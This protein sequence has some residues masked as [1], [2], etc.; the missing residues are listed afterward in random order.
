MIDINFGNL[1]TVELLHSYYKDQLCPDFNISASNQTVKTLGGHQIIARQ[2]YNQLIAGANCDTKVN[3]LKPFIAIEEGTQFTFFM[4]LNNPVFFNYTNL[5][6]T[7]PGKIYYFT[8]RNNNISNGKTFLTSKITAYNAANTY[9]PGDLALNGG[10]TSYRAISSSKPGNSFD[11]SN[12]DHW[13]A[14][15]NNQ[16]LSDNDVLQWMPSISVYQLGPPQASVSIS[17]LAYDSITTAYTQS[18]LSKTIAFANPA[19]SFTLDLSFLQPG[20]YSLTINGVQQWIYINDELTDG[21]TFAVID[22]FNDAA[23]VSSTL[24]D[25]SGALLNPAPHYSI[26]FLSRATI[27]KYILASNQPGN[28]NDTAN[29]YHF[30]NPASVIT[31][32][33]PIPLSNKALNLKLTLNNHD[34]SPIA[35]ADPQRLVTI[36]KGTDTYPCSEIFLNF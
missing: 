14:I 22:I 33:T 24:L 15:D 21:K 18:V 17:V 25:G 30:A 32:L 29:L 10:G 13:V 7:A 9:A 11:L 19:S 6:S 36:T 5:S 16:Y 27:W 8:N 28:I 4:Q 12:T 2:Y 31:S 23:P 20:K 26:Y 34:Y 3:P 35:C 1:F